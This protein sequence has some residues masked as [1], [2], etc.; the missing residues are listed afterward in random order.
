MLTYPNQ[1][2]V[3]TRELAWDAVA[4]TENLVGEPM[5]AEEALIRGGL[6][7]WN[8]GKVPLSTTLPTGDVTPAD[9]ERAGLLVPR[10]YASV[11]NVKGVQHVL[12]IVGQKYTIVQNEE[13]TDLLNVITDEGGAHF[14]AIGSLDSYRAMFAVMKMP[15]GIMI[16]G[17]DASDLF[18]GV[19]NRH[20]GNGSLTAWVTGM[21]LAC[22][23]MLRTSIRDAAAKW[24]M[25]HTS[26]IAGKIEQARTSLTL[27]WKWAEEYQAFGNDLLATPFSSADFDRILDAIE[28]V[29]DSD[30]QGWIDRQDNKRQTLRFLFN[31]ADTNE[32]GRGTKWGALNAFTEFADWYMPIRDKAPA[33]R[34]ERTLDSDQI[35][36]YKQ[37]V[38]DALVSV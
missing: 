4:D 20:D 24:K 36:K 3:S 38:V 19:V 13:C 34:A 30:K 26:G 29:S 10:H 1:T 2:T 12:G 18:L 27:T 16:G 8:V 11:A 25:R 15:T 14:H 21:R 6:D 22:T 5:T 31:E 35:D 9:F 7:N 17:Q 23:N 28:P 37:T 33:A 32:L